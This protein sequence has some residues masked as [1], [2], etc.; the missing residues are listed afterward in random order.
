MCTLEEKAF[1]ESMRRSL[2]K[3]ILLFG[4]AERLPVSVLSLSAV[5]LKDN[6]VQ[7]QKASHL[8]EKWDYIWN[9]S[10]NLFV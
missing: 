6:T 9:V 4:E 3:I 7:Q 8:K 1:I 5:F 10:Y 2:E